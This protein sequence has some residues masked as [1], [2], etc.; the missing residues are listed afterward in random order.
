[1]LCHSPGAWKEAD[2]AGQWSEARDSHVVLYTII[3]CDISQDRVILPSKPRHTCARPLTSDTA[4]S[5]EPCNRANAA[6]KTTTVVDLTRLVVLPG[7]RETWTADGQSIA[8]FLHAQCQVFQV[9]LHFV[10]ALGEFFE[11]LY[12]LGLQWGTFY[13]WW[14]FSAV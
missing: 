12:V 2:T 3:A 10:S 8:R 9:P 11:I 4:V 13:E 14:N 1:M 7:R 6:S 5:H